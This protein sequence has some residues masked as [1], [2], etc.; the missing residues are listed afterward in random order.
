MHRAGFHHVECADEAC[1]DI[2][3]LSSP[4]AYGAYPFVASDL[5]YSGLLAREGELGTFPEGIEIATG[6]REL[7]EAWTSCEHP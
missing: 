7:S 4:G 2:P 5:R 3:Y 1:E 6:V